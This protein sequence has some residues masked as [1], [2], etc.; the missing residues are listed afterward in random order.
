MPKLRN[1]TTNFSVSP[2]DSLGK[3]IA[4]Y[5]KRL[6]LTQETL[7]Q[8]IGVSRNV[9]ADY[10]KD[11]V[12]IYS[13]MIAQ[14]AVALRVTT[15]DLLGVSEQTSHEDNVLSLRFVKRIQA[16]QKLPETEQKA[17]IK[18]IDIALKSS[19]SNPNG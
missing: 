17:I 10:E 2:P 13:K 15:D 16:I 1:I 6:G 19:S 9:I 4:A 5:R 14:L 3:R 7:A 8:A 11:R 12:R 18:F